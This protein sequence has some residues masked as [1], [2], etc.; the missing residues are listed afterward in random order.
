MIRQEIIETMEQANQSL[1]YD[2][3]RI[4]GL[5]G[6]VEKALAIENERF[7][8]F[9][10]QLPDAELLTLVREV[11]QTIGQLENLKLLIEQTQPEEG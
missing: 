6:Y 7:K 3:L 5:S 9:D 4:L 10:Q 1:V 2:A 11:R 8:T